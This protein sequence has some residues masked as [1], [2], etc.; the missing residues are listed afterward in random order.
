MSLMTMKFKDFV[1]PNNP[2]RIE[3]K[4]SKTIQQ[5]VIPFYGEQTQNMGLMNRRVNGRGYFTGAESGK[6]FE[7]LQDVFRQ[8]GAGC[9]Q[10]PGQLPFQALMES[11]TF[12]GEAGE[13]VIEYSFSF[14][15]KENVTSVKSSQIVISRGEE[16]LWDY[17]FQFSVDIEELIRLNPHIRNLHSLNQGEKVVIG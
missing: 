6:T 11:L 15:E 17:A 10:L 8:S 13:N 9:L 14:V 4:E 5:T 3:V 2:T 7:A 1:W 16:S 12:I